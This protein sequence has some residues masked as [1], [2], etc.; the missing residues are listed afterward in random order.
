MLRSRA[1]SSF[2]AGARA[3]AVA[4]VVA[5]VPAG[6]AAGGS[7][8]ASQLGCA[9]VKQI[10]DHQGAAI[11][12]S[13]I[14]HAPFNLAEQFFA[15]G[16]NNVYTDRYVAHRGYCRFNERLRARPVATRDTA[17]CYLNYCEDRPTRD[18]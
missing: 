12:H 14:P 15:G 1:V 16:R 5:L 17:R 8:D 9:A 3:L 4:A 18:R 7:I 10:L 11:V 13:P 6:A 2:S